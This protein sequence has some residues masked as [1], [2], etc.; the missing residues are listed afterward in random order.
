MTVLLE[1]GRWP[2][3]I[4]VLALAMAVFREPELSIEGAFATGRWR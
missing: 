1:G 3:G 4:A 2:K